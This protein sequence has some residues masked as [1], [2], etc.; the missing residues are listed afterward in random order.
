MRLC[1]VSVNADDV[2][3]RLPFINLLLSSGQP[4]HCGVLQDCVHTF[5]HGHLGDTCSH[6]T[7][8]QDGQS[9]ENL[10]NKNGPSSHDSPSFIIT[11]THLNWSEIKETI[12]VPVL[13]QPCTLTLLLFQESQSDFSCT[14]LDR[15]TDQS[16]L[17]ILTSSPTRRN[18]VTNVKMLRWVYRR[19]RS[20]IIFSCCVETGLKSN[21][22]QR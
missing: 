19:E 9:S 7:C 1:T 5:V 21:H 13:P 16:G 12:K 18:S 3:M 2:K 4:L 11:S 6:Q 17:L 20:E 15:D 10:T 8:S 14:P 22:L